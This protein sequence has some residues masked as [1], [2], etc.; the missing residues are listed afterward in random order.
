MKTTF[1]FLFL[2]LVNTNL[3]A[4]FSETPGKSFKQLPPDLNKET[5]IF[6]KHDSVDV[7]N[8]KPKSM[9]AFEYNRLR[10]HNNVIPVSNK[11]LKE[12][13][14]EY[15]FK[16]IIASISEVDSLSK[17]NYKYVYYSP[18]FEKVK[19][20]QRMG[21]KS[22]VSFSPGK[23][24]TKTTYVIQNIVLVNLENNDLYYVGEYSETFV[25]YYKG[26]IKDFVK[27]VKKQYNL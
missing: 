12:A 2:L 22:S 15:P 24:T 4:Q 9:N 10:N 3:F 26:L 21:T 25:Y 18:A 16:Y 20:G 8:K 27:K 13:A 5:L 7:P 14:K 23:Q 6:L 1:L 17:A 11:Q 19:T